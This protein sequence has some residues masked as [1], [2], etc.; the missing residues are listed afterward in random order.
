[1]NEKSEDR[2]LLENAF[3]KIKSLKKQLAKQ[4]AEN[5]DPIAIVGMGC[6]FPG[7]ANSV[8][9][10]WGN[11]LDGKNSVVEMGNQRW[12]HSKFFDKTVP[13]KGKTYSP[14]A[15]LLDDILRFD[16]DLFR[17][18]PREAECM[19]P[20]Q[21]Q[22]LEVTW[23]ALEN[24]GM[25]IDALRG[26]NAGVFVGVMNKDHSDLLIQQLGHEEILA[27][28]NTG[29]HESVQSGRLSYFF[30][31]KGPCLTLNTACSS[32]ML[33][34]HLACQ[35]L[36]LKECDFAVAGGCNVMLSPA[37][38]IA[39]SQAAMH[40][41]AGYCKTFDE[42]ADGY[43]RAEG[44]GMVVLK[45]LSQALKDKDYI[46]SVIKGS[47]INQDGLSQGISAP[48]GPSQERVM[49]AAL[50]NAK[51][52]AKDVAFVEAHGTG[53]KLGDP[54]ELRALGAVYGKAEKRQQP[55]LVGAVKTNIGHAE[56]AA[57][58]ASIIKLAKVVE[59]GKIP[60]NLHCSKVNAHIDL[61]AEN[62][63]LCTP[64]TEWPTIQA[65]SP[66]IA[67]VSS[68]GFSGSNSHLI[69]ESIARNVPSNENAIKVKSRDSHLLRISGKS[70]AALTANVDRAIEFL[71]V[72]SDENL[73]DICYSYNT[74]R[75][76]FEYSILAA[77][78]SRAEI[79]ESAKQELAR[80]PQARS[81]RPGINTALY[82]GDLG[83]AEYQVCGG[84]YASSPVFSHTYDEI[85]TEITRVIECDISLL[86]WSTTPTQDVTAATLYQAAC[87]YALNKLWVSL[88]LK[89]SLVISP[90][91]HEY[92][93]SAITLNLS[94]NKLA[95]ILAEK[96]L[97]ECSG[98]TDYKIYRC[99]KVSGG[100][101]QCE[102][103]VLALDDLNTEFVTAKTQC[104]VHLGSPKDLERINSRENFPIVVSGFTE[105]SDNPWQEISEQLCNTYRQ[106]PNI[107]L[108]AWDKGY[109]RRKIPVPSYAFQGE[110]YWFDGIDPSGNNGV[111]KVRQTENTDDQGRFENASDFVLHVIAD[112]A[113]TQTDKIDL[114]SQLMGSMGFDSLMIVD[115]RDR[116]VKRYPSLSRLSFEAL[117]EYTLSQLLEQVD[118]VADKGIESANSEQ[119][120]LAQKDHSES[121]QK[122]IKWLDGWNP[123]SDESTNM[124]KSVNRLDKKWV[125][126]HQDN[127]VLLGELSRVGE[128]DWFA[129]QVYQCN[130]HS[131]FYEHPQDHVP[132]LY[133]IEATRQFGLA[134]AHLFHNVPMDRPFVL[135]DMHI[136]FS[137]FAEKTAPL[138]LL[139]EYTD[140]LF[141]D[142]VLNRT[143]SQCYVIQNG[144]SLGRVTGRGLI[145]DAKKYSNKRVEETA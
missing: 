110:R 38:S 23:E 25:P 66:R 11:L 111:L 109:D 5:S 130:D 126:K 1:M 33:T 105:T 82:L 17:I 48:N 46:Y 15:G 128:S 68:F 61:T 29:N 112:I 13:T 85:V 94:A 30:D 115:L 97:S 86:P 140:T 108:A 6:R 135:D 14:R 69:M 43:V 24:A 45:P 4:D 90:I 41:K 28:M 100:I 32:S 53:T 27:Q 12:E 93:V 75:R 64:K 34:V 107:D 101:E 79:I 67:G 84:L 95:A 117:Y 118:A 58:I 145:M 81:V 39:Q 26:S 102:I 49:R 122:A 60:G 31:F 10:Y 136:Q 138:Y 143:K 65:T 92:L 55:L 51:V 20:Q 71:T 37:S 114:E 76:N 119:E 59:T 132:G 87:F 89:A 9:E 47:A 8:D 141:V 133:L 36:R 127:N 57:G 19:D 56:S 22:L 72:H 77:G 74:G 134:C 103:N 125:H 21:R 3:K 137:Q 35:S 144:H 73:A 120:Q 44:C 123:D 62:L 70:E 2:T 7:S 124:A 40:S 80:K 106:T 129:A 83:E 131:F 113:K 16:A 18:T 116:M 104:L 88:G 91:P 121:L 142:G 42:S 99:R 52:Q 78:K 96:N 63:S 139:A 50:V 98:N 54:I